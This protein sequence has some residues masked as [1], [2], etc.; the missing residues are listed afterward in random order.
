M[1]DNLYSK[2]ETANAENNI[3]VFSSEWESSDAV[4]LT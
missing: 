4:L 3:V 2:S 1:D